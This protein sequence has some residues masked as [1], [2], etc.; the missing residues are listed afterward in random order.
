MLQR[1]NDEELAKLSDELIAISKRH[2]E[3]EARCMR[4][5]AEVVADKMLDY[6][7]PQP[8]PSKPFVLAQYDAMNPQA[9]QEFDN[10][11]PQWRLGE[12]EN[13]PKEV[14]RVL[15]ENDSNKYNLEL[16][17]KYVIDDVLRYHKIMDKLSEYHEGGVTEDQVR[18]TFQKKKEE[19]T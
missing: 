4:A 15:L 13:W 8:L 12:A 6:F 2:A 10:R 9:K 5:T 17:A 16:W 7:S 14:R 1:P 3:N 18:N 19:W 11:N